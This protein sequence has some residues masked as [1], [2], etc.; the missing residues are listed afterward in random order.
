MRVG[1]DVL[2]AGDGDIEFRLFPSHKHDLA[3]PPMVT[4]AREHQ[5]ESA[6]VLLG[7]L[8]YQDEIL[9]RLPHSIK[10]G[11]TSDAAI[12]LAVYDHLGPQGLEELEGEF[13]LVLWDGR[14]RQLYALRDPLSC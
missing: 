2:N 13:S 14:L 12:A 9:S 5:S 6:A 7:Q 1:F 3:R 4:F 10:Q 8:C 11:C